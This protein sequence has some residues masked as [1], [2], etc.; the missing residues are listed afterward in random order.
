MLQAQLLPQALPGG[1]PL[2]R[3]GAAHQVVQGR[4]AQGVGGAPQLL[5]GLRGAAAQQ[6]CV[7]AQLL[8]RGGEGRGAEWRRKV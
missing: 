5:Q 6:G 8:L 7:V 2:L 4:Q 3:Q 1:A